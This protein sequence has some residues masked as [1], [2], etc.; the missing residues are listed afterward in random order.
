M[1]LGE[2]QE[3]F[4]K[5]IWEKAPINSGDLVKICDSEFGWKKS[6]TYTVLRK[7]CDKGLFENDNGTVK[8]LMTVEE[9]QSKKS[10]EVVDEFFEGSLPAFIAAFT[11]G[12]K[13]SSEEVEELQRLIDEMKGR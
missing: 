11:N 9:Y 7:L 6:T 4:A 13:M 10:E 5:L 8:V 2:V 1:E 3:K 12:K